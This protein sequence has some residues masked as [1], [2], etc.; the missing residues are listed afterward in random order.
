M[1]KIKGTTINNL[2]KDVLIRA[3]PN[4]VIKRC[5]AIILAVSRTQRVIGRIKLLV[6]SI[7]TIKLIRAIGVPCGTKWESMWFVFF[8]QP[9][10]L[11]DNQAIKA[12]GRVITTCEVKEKT[13]G[14]RA[15][16]FIKRID[17]NKERIKPTSPFFTTF[18]V[19]E[20]S[21]SKNL[22]TLALSLLSMFHNCIGATMITII[23][24]NHTLL[25][26]DE[27]SKIENKLTIIVL[28]WL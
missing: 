1:V 25:K 20:T 15:I 18:R 22:I 2:P 17:K 3:F 13:W 6:N 19:N 12:R 27:G 4:N 10:K 14:K 11:I 7:N 8:N 23:I 5:P 26:D 28:V 16:T 9:I 21:F 24:S